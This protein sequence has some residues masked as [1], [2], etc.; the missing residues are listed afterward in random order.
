MSREAWGDEPPKIKEEHC[1][2]CGGTHHAE[3]CEI[4]ALERE[5]HALRVDA[6]RLNWLSANAKEG[7]VR[8]P[9][10]TFATVQAWVITADKKWSLREAI[11]MAMRQ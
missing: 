11:D 6:K 7:T 10:M 3:G 1:P 5:L 8:L 9:D 4:G 2:L